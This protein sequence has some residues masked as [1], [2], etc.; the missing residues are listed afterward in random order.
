LVV[1]LAAPAMAAPRDDSPMDRFERAISRLM[2]Q[3]EKIVHVTDLPVISPV[4]P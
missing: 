2:N 4:K 3:I 1:S